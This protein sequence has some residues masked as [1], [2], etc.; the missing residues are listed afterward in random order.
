MEEETI[1]LREYLD[2]ALRRWWLLLLGPIIAGLLALGFAVLRPSAPVEPTA[3]TQYTATT[4]L[5]M[6]GIEGLDNYPDLVKTQ[7]VLLDAIGALGL[8]L[9]V[10]ELRA[11][12]SATQGTESRMVKIEI[13]DQDPNMAVS[14]AD[15]VAQ[16][17]VQYVQR[18]REPQLAAAQEVLT[19]HLADLDTAISAEAA[20]DVAAALTSLAQRPAIIAPAEVFEDSQDAVSAVHTT[21]NVVLASVLG[22]VMAVIAV[23]L[24]E[25]LQNPIRSPAQLE[26]RLGLANLGI[27]PRWPKRKGPTDQPTLNE[28]SNTAWAEA[29]RQVATTFDLTAGSAGVKT[30]VVASPDTREGRTSL[31]ANLG[32]ALATSWRN[33]V[34][35]DAD[36]RRPSLHLRLDLDNSV[37]L[38]NLLSDPSTEIVDI[39]QNTHYQRL[40]VIT[41]GPIPSNPVELLR[42]PRMIWLLQQLKE[43]AHIVL[44]D[45][46]PILATT[47]GV[48]LA[49]QV[50]GVVVAANASDSRQDAMKTAVDGLQKA[51]DKILGFVWNRATVR[52]FSDY[53]RR[54]RYYRQ[55]GSPT[56][57]PAVAESG[58]T[59]DRD[60]SKEAVATFT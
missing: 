52:P 15:G 7:P 3:P 16:S 17:F 11:K 25:Y 5:L 29:V 46:P 53:S 4:I 8:S 10:A 21:R 23:F 47:D 57:A 59:L 60:Q 40:K 58:P 24:F 55:L 2:V 49:S 48:L 56:L 32:V 9:S 34:L 38:S 12:L 37:G 42:C 18:I 54:E 51:N 44:V 27:I 36:L 1:D 30:V 28:G 6:E 22:G 43:S 20:E 33:V 50:D 14:I 45:T 41:S 39:I 13:I 26:R 31:V 35:V 19:K